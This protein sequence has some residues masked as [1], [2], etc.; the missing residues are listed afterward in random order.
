M[1][2]KNAKNP[3]KQADIIPNVWT[4]VTPAGKTYS[5]S[6]K[7]PTGKMLSDLISGPNRIVSSDD[8]DDISTKE[9]Q[10]MFLLGWSDS[11]DDE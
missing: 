11:S 6:Q 7:C 2:I 3:I 9:K 8:D 1:N 5:F 4:I 10:L